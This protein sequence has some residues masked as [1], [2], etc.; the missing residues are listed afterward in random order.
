MIVPYPLTGLPPSDAL[1]GHCDRSAPA[2]TE[3]RQA[4][5]P[6]AAA[7]LVEERRDD[8]GTGRPDR[9]TK[10]NSPAVDV[11]PRPVEPELAAVG[12]DLRG[13][14]FVDLDEIESLERQFDPV[15]QPPDTGDRRK[16][17]PS[18]LDFRLGVAD[19]PGKGR[20]AAA[21]AGFSLMRR[22]QK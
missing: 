5:A 18:R 13:K 20:V 19:D 7:E 17:Q 2:Q 14:R 10:R 6:V 11:D 8:P 21:T 4:I 22:Y 9:V 16:E 12:Q 1:E 15:E 3:R